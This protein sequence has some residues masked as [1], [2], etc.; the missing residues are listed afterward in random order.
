[1][2]ISTIKIENFRSIRRATIDFNK[3]NILIGTNG[4][5]KSNIISAL[6]YFYK[7]L[8]NNDD[9]INIFDI[10]N[11]FSNYVKISITFDFSEIVKICRS[12]LKYENS[13]YIKYFRAILNFANDTKKTVTLFKIKGRKTVWEGATPK[14]RRLIYDLFPLYTVD[15]RQVNL[16]DWSNL[17]TYIGDLI[18]IDNDTSEKL[19]NNIEQDIIKSEY[20]LNN[21]LNDIQASLNKANIYLRKFRPKEYA[22]LLTQVYFKGNK[23]MFN[24]NNLEYS[25]N[26]TNAFNYTNILIEILNLMA[27]KKIKEPIVI[28]D[29]PELSLHHSFMDE[30]IDNIFNASK[31]VSF[32][33]A[34][35][36]PRIVKYIMKYDD[37]ISNIY[38]VD[39]EELYTI[40]AK[41][42]MFERIEY[43]SRARINDE[44]ANAYFAKLILA[45]EGETEQELFN[46][47]Y[48]REVF[49]TLKN[50]DIVSKAMSEDPIMHIIS[51]HYRRYAVPI[52]VAYDMDKV[53][54]IDINKNTVILKRDFI[55]NFGKEKYFYTQKRFNDSTT[56][57]RI[58]QMAQKCKFHYTYPFYE[59]HDET[60]QTFINI[61]KKY[62]KGYNH[63]AFETTVEG[64]LINREN[65]EL[66]WEFIVTYIRFQDIDNLNDVFN[67][68][69]D[70]NKLNFTRLL[71][72]GKSDYLLSFKQI[73]KQNIHIDLKI[74]NAIET[75]MQD[76]TSGW[77]S[78]WIKYFCLRCLDIPY[79]TGTFQIFRK[80]LEKDNN[81]EKIQENFRL[82]FNELYDI[83]VTMKRIYNS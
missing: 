79:A 59:S 58:N 78:S 81:R 69:D 62:L 63:M 41:M 51:P 75:S 50:V 21:I 4:S 67:A 14:E 30:L 73:I 7:N 22:A 76:K 35:H 40:I 72:N 6:E 39:K 3:I 56:Y 15:S 29:E 38:H 65:L 49:P 55:N 61:I 20:N 45:I 8:S 31:N 70:N 10:N 13:D 44:Y 80:E 26:G 1:M 12:H 74:K 47:Q 23:F 19:Q 52:I 46:N 54:S 83:I 66:F 5:G 25:S 48:L 34:T 37:G 18:K 57:K 28:M 11:K 32:F 68:F 2:S 82:Q 42:N 9:D 27:K 33:I 64:A 16:D 24:N 43:R 71:F 60:Y 36:S 77:V 17:W 53:F